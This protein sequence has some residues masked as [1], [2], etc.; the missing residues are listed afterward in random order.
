ML[1]THSRLISVA[2]DGVGMVVRVDD[3]WEARPFGP[4]GGPSGTYASREDAI[5]SV[6]AVAGDVICCVGHLADDADR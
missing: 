5:D 1:W 4:D 6:E 3:G 2:D